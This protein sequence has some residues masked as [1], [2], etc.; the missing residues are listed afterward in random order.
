MSVNVRV[1]SAPA[2]VKHA[3]QSTTAMILTVY[4]KVTSLLFE[5]K[6]G[7]GVEGKTYW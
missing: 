2:V 6:R 7:K 3:R 5:G 1:F 4:F